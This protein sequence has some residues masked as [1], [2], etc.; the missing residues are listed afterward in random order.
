MFLCI[1]WVLLSAHSQVQ[2]CF[3][4]TQVPRLKSLYDITVQKESTWKLMPIIS[5]K[6]VQTRGNVQTEKLWWTNHQLCQRSDI[7]VNKKL[8]TQHFLD[9][10]LSVRIPFVSFF[11]VRMCGACSSLCFLLPF[12]WQCESVWEQ[13]SS[14]Q[15]TCSC[16]FWVDF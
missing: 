11:Y 10:F 3:R 12:S 7:N 13:W 2:K 14:H 1:C 16:V 4:R 8:Q 15:A 9:Y 6:R 5:D